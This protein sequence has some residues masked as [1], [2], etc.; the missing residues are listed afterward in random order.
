MHLP[1]VPPD[2]L[3]NRM[4]PYTLLLTWNFAEEILAQQAEYRKRGGK[5]IVPI[6]EVR[7]V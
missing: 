4:P 1:I 7:I 5:F 3:V 2:E 6:P